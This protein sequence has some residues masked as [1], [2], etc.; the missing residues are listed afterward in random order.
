MSEQNN[1]DVIVNK[2]NEKKKDLGGK[3]IIL[4]HHYQRKEIVALADYIGDSY[5][6][7]KQA[8]ADKNAEYIVFCG[9]HFMAESAEILSQP[10]QIVQMPDTNAGC[11]MADMADH[12]IVEKAW[13]EVTAFLGDTTVIPVVYMNADAEIK[14][15]CGR[16]GG[17]VCTSSNA[18]AAFDWSFERGEKIFFFPD[19]HLGRNTGNKMGFSPDEMVVW[20]PGKPLGGNTPE[21]IKKAKILLWDGYCLVHTRFTTHHIAEKRAKYPDAKLVVHPECRQE[22]V[23]LADAVGSTSF[24]VD[25]VKEAPAGSTIIIGTEI[26]L[27]RRLSDNYPDKNILTLH[28][29]LC[30]NM[31]KISPEKLLHTLENIGKENIIKVSDKVKNDAKKALDRMLELVN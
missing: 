1:I 24:I 12:Y 19:Q 23:A 26:N 11:W 28:D 10:H 16:N 4:A 9:V 30:P 25:Y 20:Q 22:V 15:I 18:H 27:V 29:S 5:G 31:Y 6:L 8:A 14:A 2:I 7:S 17:V 13:E 21:T 3:L